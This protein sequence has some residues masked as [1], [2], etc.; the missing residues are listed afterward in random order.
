M[1]NWKTVGGII[2]VIGL[3]MTAVGGGLLFLWRN[4]TKSTWWLWLLLIVGILMIIGGGIAALALG[5]SKGVQATQYTVDQVASKLG[6]GKP[7][8]TLVF[9]DVPT[10]RTRTTV[11]EDVPLRR[12]NNL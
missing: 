12:V 2:A 3:I 5:T 1:V 6:Y 10:V 8:E 4:S 7:T 9:E 11:R